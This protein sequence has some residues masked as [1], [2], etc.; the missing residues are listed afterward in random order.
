VHPRTEAPLGVLGRIF[1]GSIGLVPRASLPRLG[2]AL[3]WLVGAVLRV[4]RVHVE[5]AMKRAGIVRSRVPALAAEMYRSLGTSV[6]EILWLAAHRNV[7][8]SELAS[9][10]EWSHAILSG[11]HER[12]CGVVLA[13]AHAG[14]WELAAAALAERYPLT[15]VVKPMSVGWVERLC[16][17]ARKARGIGLA[18][19][20]NALAAS[21]DALS[22]GE[23]VAMLI[24]QVPDRASHSVIADF[25]CGRADVD[26]SP[27]ALA[28]A[29][30][31]PLVVAVSRRVGGGH[32]LEALACLDPPDRDRR[33]WAVEATRT[34]TRVFERWVHA[35]P[36]EW[37]WMHRRWKA[38]PGV[39]APRRGL[40]PGSRGDQAVP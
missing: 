37:L 9:I 1:A 31:V 28:A 26:R 12:G 18:S 33:A 32:V 29:M 21:R 14:N 25:L 24:D 34:A 5:S 23:M 40:G 13:T 36:S 6:V 35:H 30:R 4:R 7:P 8:A 15:V 39:T 16:R 19:P 3:A 22:R 20:D 38:A 17:G 11:A 27:A 2:A 10:D